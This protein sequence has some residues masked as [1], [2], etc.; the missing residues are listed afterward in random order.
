MATLLFIE[1]SLSHS[2]AAPSISALYHPD[3]LRMSV[4]A[5]KRLPI[6]TLPGYRCRPFQRIGPTRARRVTMAEKL[7][8]RDAVYRLEDTIREIR[9]RF[10][11]DQGR[12]DEIAFEESKADPLLALAVPL[13]EQIAERAPLPGVVQLA[14]EIINRCVAELV[15]S[16]VASPITPFLCLLDDDL[17]EFGRRASKRCCAKKTG[18]CGSKGFPAQLVRLP[19]TR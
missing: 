3:K 10:A 2:G 5:V 15:G 16:D 19:P 12:V 17:V 1:A 18:N 4:G 6:I 9:N 7:Q 11:D 13:V 8:L 14:T